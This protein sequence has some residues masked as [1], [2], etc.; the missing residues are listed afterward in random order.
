MDDLDRIAQ[1][2]E[3]SEAR[4]STRTADIMA[5]EVREL[6][7]RRPT[8]VSPDTA[9]T[10]ILETML[11]EG[12]GCVLVTEGDQLVGIL[13]ERDVLLKV[14]AVGRSSAGLHAR[15]LMTADPETLHPD[16]MVATALNRM[17]VG[18]YRHVP[19]VDDRGAPVGVV[20]VKDIV[21]LIVDHFPH[22]VLTQP[23]SGVPPFRSADGA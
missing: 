15:D 6:V 16:Q 20:S 23:P 22:E 18:G 17:S 5:H 2:V 3:T 7:R 14:T 13:T 19:V 12:I 10:V 8:T 21:R 1:D 9:L 11:R 4:E